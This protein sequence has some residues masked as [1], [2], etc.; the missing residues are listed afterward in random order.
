MGH[1]DNGMAQLLAIG[2]ILFVL[3]RFMSGNGTALNL[4]SIE[5]FRSEPLDPVK[6]FT[7]TV[8]AT[9]QPAKEPE[10]KRNHN[11][12]TDLQQDCFDALK[13]LGITRIK[14]RKFIVSE[15]FNKHNPSTVQEFLKF[16]LN[17]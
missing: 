17:K 3:Y 1:E 9:I 5:V 8:N 13:A 15:T 2:M 6:P 4:D 16:A 14:E 12:Y 11:G 10:V 7:A